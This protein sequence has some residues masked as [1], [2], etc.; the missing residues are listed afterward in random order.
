M[1]NLIRYP[2]QVYNNYGLQWFIPYLM[3]VCLIA[4]P[5]LILEIA[6]GQA[7][8]GGSVVAYNTMHH[9]LKGT[10]LN[11][12]YVGF[13]VGPYFAVNLGKSLFCGPTII[14]TEILTTSP[15]GL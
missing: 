9:R 4:I 10:G 8:R 12:I 2:S 3:T 13:V 1:G 15:H 5:V 11:L 7:Y 6:I 14:V